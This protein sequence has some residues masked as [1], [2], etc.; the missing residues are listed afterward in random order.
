MKNYRTLKWSILVGSLAASWIIPASAQT[1]TVTNGLQLWLK[2]DAGI[3]TGAGG[4]VTAWQDQSGKGNNASQ[5]A[6]DM[7]PLL[8]NNAINGKPVLR[9]DGVD[10]FLEVLDSDSVSIAGDITTFFVVKFDDFVTYRAVWAKTKANQPGPNDWYALP[11]S[12]IPRAYRGNGLG[13]NGSADGGKALTTNEFLV[14]GWDMAGS[15]LRHYLGG[16]FNGGRLVSPAVIADADT[17]LLIGTRED[18]VTI[19]MGDIAEV[20]IYDRALAVSNRV[21]VIDYLNQKYSLSSNLDPAGDP[22]QDGLTNQEELAALTD[23]SK[24]DTDGDGV[25]DGAEVHQYHSD[26]IST[27][28]DGDFLNDGFE[29]TVLHTDPT[30]ADTDGDGFSDYYEFHLFTDPLDPNSKPKQT[31]ANLFTG[32]DAGQGLDLTGNFIYAISFGATVDRAPYSTSDGTLTDV[33]AFGQIH[34]ALFTADDVEGVTTVASQVANNWNNDVIYGTSPAQQVLSSVMASIR[35]SDAGNAVD[36]QDHR[37]VT[38]TMSKLQIGASYKLQLL[39]GERLWARGFDI[40]INGRPAAQAFAPFQW[41][42]DFVGPANATPRTNG[43]VLTH[44]FIANITNVTFVLDGRPITDP[45]MADHNAIINGATLELVSAAVDSD[46]DGLWDAWEMDNF[47][48]L[49]QT[50]AGDPDADG[51]TNAQE[52]VLNTDPNKADTDGDALSDGQ[53]VSTT[54]TDP[55]KADT[56]GDGLTDGAEVNTYRTDPLKT[57]TDGDGI[58]DS[59]EI[60]VGD[61]PLTVEAATVLSN[62][63][64]QPITGGDPGE[65]LDLQGNFRYAI[66]VG[67]AGAAGKAGDADFTAD[68]A[69][70]ITVTAPAEIRNWSSPEYGDTVAD[71]VIE[72]VTQSIRYGPTVRVV[73]S[74]LVPGSTYKVQSLFYEQGSVGRGFNIY[75]DGVL[76]AQDFSPPETQGGVALTSSAALV[77]AELLTHRHALTLVATTSGRTRPDFND[78]NAILDGV[79]LEILNQVAPPTLGLTR[80]ADGKVTITTDSTLQVADTVTGIYTN[81]PVK[82]VTIDPRTAGGQKFYRGARP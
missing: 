41:Q 61:D 40:S 35:W 13:M 54:R 79:T 76:L 44:N 59:D 56:D 17:S 25:N 8:V 39:F 26:P 30:K 71:N 42:G 65:G 51:L 19:M 53:E 50:S 23:P 82:T 57:D 20:L 10:D 64:I 37:A 5:A 16:S 47:G 32:P 81:L 80:E 72:K 70:G 27:D 62:I 21:A 46:G 63:L 36:D 74:G 69:P 66:N 24:P 49:N 6:A 73:L 22:D 31:T 29:V 48:N 34:D 2:A 75:A 9:F 7:S 52:F 15:Q 55:L 77:S 78:P 28:T 1:L 68:N 38:V 12:G 11:G 4:I 14:A 67:T 60:R 45:A 58:S 18:R 33:P 43:V 3:T